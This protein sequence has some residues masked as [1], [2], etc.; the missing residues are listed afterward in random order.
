MSEEIN[1]KVAEGHVPGAVL[2]FGRQTRECLTEIKM[3][4]RTGVLIREDNEGGTLFV[5]EARR[6]VPIGIRPEDSRLEP[7]MMKQNDNEWFKFARAGQSYEPRGNF[8]GP[9]P[10]STEKVIA[11]CKPYADES[12]KKRPVGKMAVGGVEMRRL[13]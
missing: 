4:D 12:L 8:T 6:S 9:I 2:D 10:T 5:I 11:T 1:F 7:Y 3:G 13:G